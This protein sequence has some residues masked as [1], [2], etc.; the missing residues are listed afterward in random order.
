MIRIKKKFGSF[1]EARDFGRKLMQRCGYVRLI[2]YPI[3][4][5]SGMYTWDVK[6]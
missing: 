6:P 2:R 5:G 1:A 3:F 4:W